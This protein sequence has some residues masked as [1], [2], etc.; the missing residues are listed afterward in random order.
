MYGAFHFDYVDSLS[1]EFDANA[2]AETLRLRGSGTTFINYAVLDNGHVLSA[3]DFHSL[4]GSPPVNWGLSTLP[5]ITDEPV[6]DGSLRQFQIDLH[7]GVYQYFSKPFSL[8]GP[9]TPWPSAVVDYVRL[10]PLPGY[11]Y[12]L[13]S[14]PDALLPYISF[15]PNII[16]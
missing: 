2:R 12:C 3:A 15:A 4:G 13:G 14:I 8:Q 5:T 9:P 1:I 6:S 16:I 11:V 10:W 7:E